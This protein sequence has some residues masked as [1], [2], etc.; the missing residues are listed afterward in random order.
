MF[1]FLVAGLNSNCALVSLLA[2]YIFQAHITWKIKK[3]HPHFIFNLSLTS[4]NSSFLWYLITQPLS[5]NHMMCVC[6]CYICDRKQ[7]IW[8]LW[9]NPLRNEG[10]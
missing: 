10:N 6:A 5:D 4:N 7:S 3:N 2:S 8:S 9:N 1:E